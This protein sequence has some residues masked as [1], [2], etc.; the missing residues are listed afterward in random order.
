MKT[1]CKVK[2]Y[3]ERNTGTGYLTQLIQLNL[4]VEMLAGSLPWLLDRLAGGNESIRDLYFRTTARRNL[5]WKHTQVSGLE[6]LK[7]ARIDDV[8]FITLTKNPYS[9]LLSLYRRPY[10]GKQ[11]HGK[12]T[13]DSFAAFLQSPWPT[14]EREN[15]VEAFPNP[16]VM[17]NE[18]NRA[19]LNLNQGICVQNLRYEDLL[20][21]P[22]VVIT[23]LATTYAMP[24]KQAEFVNLTQSTKEADP[25]KGF[26]YYHAYYLEER[27]R[28]KFDPSLLTLVNESLD[29]EVVK[30]FRYE[31]ITGK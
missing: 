23:D 3:G 6:E 20:R 2:I 31:M 7:E 12:Q 18:K 1:V 22:E 24:R 29:E 17:W 30:R 16:I 5:G 10:H 9:W 25:D 14:V 21:D 27:W 28:D 19:Y 4:D 15:H 26:N 13:M 8:V 11:N